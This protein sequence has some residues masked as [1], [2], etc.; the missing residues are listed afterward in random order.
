ML[1]YIVG[2]LLGL[3]ATG[4]VAA[5]D[6]VFEEI[7][8]YGDLF[9]RWDNTRWLINTEVAL[10]YA[11]TMHREENLGFRTKMF[12]IRAVLA[13]SKEYRLNAKNYEVDCELED[14]GIRMTSWDR[15]RSYQFTNQ[16]KA[17]KALEEQGPLEEA[18][19]VIP[20]PK[21]ML[22]AEY[23]DL[24]PV[25]VPMPY[26]GPKLRDLGVMDVE[27]EVTLDL[28]ANGKVKNV[29]VQSCPE[30]FQQ[31]TEE[32]LATWRFKPTDQAVRT[33]LTIPFQ[34][35]VDKILH[36]VD[37]RLTG[38]KLQ[39]QVRDDGQV[40]NVDIEGLTSH[41]E[42]TRRINETLRL[43]LSR[44]MA[45]FDMKLRKWN[46]LSEGQWVEYNP[47]LMAMPTPDFVASRGSSM[48]VHQLNKYKGELVVQ[49]VGR[50][51]ISYGD[52]A[53]ENFFSTKFNGVSIYDREEG[54]MTE[55]VWSLFGTPTASSAMADGSA[56]APY[57]HAG[58]IRVL[59]DTEQADVGATEE[60]AMPG[61]PE[62][63]WL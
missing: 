20:D 13:C 12:Q 14:I 30:P 49:S 26:Y 59:G 53:S 41:D 28:N 3:L 58:R 43:I 54:Y 9:A 19:V 63:S 22:V 33:S 27:C 39:I 61:A 50:G 44:M 42:R 57:W 47:E 55:R 40:Q 23:V 18:E 62:G 34:V 25:R 2:L 4:T 56:G 48:L 5:Q 24:K 32:R 8:V 1:R 11:L 60:V 52:G 7:T 38:A 16:R 17:F 29:Y 6:D 36:E 21:G 35:K 10:P 51:T 37:E 45:G 15:W 46:N 31:A